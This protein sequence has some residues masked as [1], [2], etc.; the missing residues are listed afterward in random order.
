[1]IEKEMEAT[2]ESLVEKVA[3]LENQVV[4]TLKSATCSVQETVAT[5][6]DAVTGT[7]ESVQ[8]RVEDVKEGVKEAFDV[9][10]HIQAHPWMCV[11]CA[12]LTGVA[13]GVFLGNQAR[14]SPSK[15]YRPSTSYRGNGH[16]E[17]APIADAMASAAETASSATKAAGT[18][19]PGL[20]GS[21]FGR[22]TDEIRKLGEEALEQLTTSLKT[23]LHEQLPKVI[24]TAVAAFNPLAHLAAQANEPRGRT[25]TTSAR[26][27]A[28]Y[29]S[30]R[31]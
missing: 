3:A 10:G 21:L 31:G 8:H 24:E 11:S 6:K 13:L 22:F 1:M 7:V 23:N 16:A 9:A 14:S 28:G 15:A 27:R 12:T 26:E 18:E 20:F 2:R 17:R 19:Q 30:D 4:G 25:E 29:S 5:V